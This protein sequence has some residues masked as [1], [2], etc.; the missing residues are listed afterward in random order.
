MTKKTSN[1]LP[2]PKLALTA[3]QMDG[4]KKVL[5]GRRFRERT[6]S[7]V[8]KCLIDGNAHKFAQRLYCDH[9]SDADFSKFPMFL[10]ELDKLLY[11]FGGKIKEKPTVSE[12]DD[13][14][15]TK[16]SRERD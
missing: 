7:G 2:R 9:V 10:T 14:D 5:S 13:I 11:K 6:S 16:R 1:K 12:D 3:S 8:L 4:I 15:T